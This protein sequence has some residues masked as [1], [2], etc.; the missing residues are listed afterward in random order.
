MIERALAVFKLGMGDVV[1]TKIGGFLKKS[2]YLLTVNCHSI[3]EGFE[4]K[5][6]EF[7]CF[8]VATKHI[9]LEM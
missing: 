1:C 7:L 8:G 9:G 3:K 2:F 4:K 6:M 5:I